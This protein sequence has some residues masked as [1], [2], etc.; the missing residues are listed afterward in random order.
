[1]A[2]AAAIELRHLWAP[3]Q[4]W[5]AL[6]GRLLGGSPNCTR[7]PPRRRRHLPR[8]RATSAHHV[9]DCT[10]TAAAT[11]TAKVLDLRE[12][13]SGSTGLAVPVLAAQW[14]TLCGGGRVTDQAALRRLAVDLLVFAAD[15]DELGLQGALWVLTE[16]S[17]ADRATVWARADGMGARAVRELSEIFAC[18]P[19]EVMD[20]LT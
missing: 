12:G 7:Q 8:R 2:M 11:R 4:R 10:T 9:T 14:A 19:R 5:W 16:L 3:I 20:R 6:A 1:M 17:D 13:V 18:T 15:D